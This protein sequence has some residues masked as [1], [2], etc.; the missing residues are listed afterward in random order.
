MKK[1]ILSFTLTSLLLVGSTISAIAAGYVTY[2]D[3]Q[4]YANYANN[5]TNVHTKTENSQYIDNIVTRMSNTTTTVF[6]AAN[7]SYNK[8]SNT[9]AVE[10][11]Q[12][13]QNFRMKFN[14]TYNKGSGVCMGMEDGWSS[15]GR[16]VVSGQ[17]DFR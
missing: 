8:I 5:Y 16:G 15:S 14:F 3:Y 11:T 7:S 6:W 2:T 1:K 12:Y 17:V 9:Y 4:L 10:N 13:N